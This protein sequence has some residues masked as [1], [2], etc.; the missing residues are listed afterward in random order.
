M[1]FRGSKGSSSNMKTSEGFK[2]CWEPPPLLNPESAP[3]SFPWP[4]FKWNGN[5]CLM[6]WHW[7]CHNTTIYW[8]TYEAMAPVC[9]A[10]SFGPMESMKGGKICRKNWVT[11]THFLWSHW[12]TFKPIG[13]HYAAESLVQGKLVSHLQIMNG[14]SWHIGFIMSFMLMLQG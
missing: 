10:T 11:L 2:V 1:H 4:G 5:L 14:V 3:Y 13:I 6:L 12:P 7:S 9:S 8:L